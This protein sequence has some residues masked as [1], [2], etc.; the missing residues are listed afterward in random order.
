MAIKCRFPFQFLLLLNQGAYDVDGYIGHLFIG[1][2][3]VVTK[4]RQYG[5]GFRY[6][7]IRFLLV[8]LQNHTQGA[9]A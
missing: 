9:D 7:Q 1:K 3:Q 2:E 4:L 8:S 5:C 6:R